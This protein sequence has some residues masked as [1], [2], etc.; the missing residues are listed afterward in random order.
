MASTSNRQPTPALHFG[1]FSPE[2]MQ[3]RCQSI[4]PHRGP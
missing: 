3:S 1:D 4:R 2:T